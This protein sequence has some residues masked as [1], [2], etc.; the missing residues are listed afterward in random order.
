M[1]CLQVLPI[2]VKPMLLQAT[3]PYDLL[4]GAD[5]AASAVR[6]AL[7]HI[8]PANYVRRY[9]H[10]QVYS[11]TQMTPD[12]P[13]KVSPHVVF[14]AHCKGTNFAFCCFGSGFCKRAPAES[15]MHPPHQAP[16]LPPG[17]AASLGLQ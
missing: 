16:L 3:I 12:D 10:K 6:S 17:A 14:Q 15:G 4:V 1:T 5:G 8:M 9:R 7:Q 2:D 13:A 11:M